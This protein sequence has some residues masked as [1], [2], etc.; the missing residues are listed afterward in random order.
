MA[1]SN[2]F[3]RPLWDDDWYVFPL[4]AGNS[5]TQRTAHPFSPDVDVVEDQ[6]G[7]TISAELPGMDKSDVS[8]KI[9][10]DFLVISGEKKKEDVKEDAEH[11]YKRVERVYGTF[12]R[13]FRL[14][15]NV[16]RGGITASFEN[17]VLRVTLQ[18]REPEPKKAI[19][20]EIH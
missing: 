5:S 3:L 10:E 14:P 1:L 18:K 11:H 15:E 12:S 19:N 20:I 9:E 6:K 8:I 17:G 13:Q 4:R 16:D 7:F 2:P